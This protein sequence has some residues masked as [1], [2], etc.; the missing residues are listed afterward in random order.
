MPKSKRQRFTSDAF[1]KEKLRRFEMACGPEDD[2][3]DEGEAPR[4]AQALKKKDQYERAYRGAVV[5]E[6]DWN[7]F[8]KTMATPLPVTLRLESSTTAGRLLACQIMA[9]GARQ[10]AR[11]PTKLEAGSFQGA[12][13]LPFDRRALKAE[14]SLK[15]L[16]DVLSRE[17][18]LGTLSRQ[19]CRV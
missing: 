6:E 9:S 13:T 18:T 17:M 1:T 12:L 11:P 4:S 7:E 2:D 5:A 16:R 8:S 15:H 10:T 3:D 19:V 14:P